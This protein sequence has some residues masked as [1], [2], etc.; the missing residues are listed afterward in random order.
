MLAAELALD[1]PPD[2]AEVLLQELQDCSKAQHIHETLVRPGR[3]WFLD[4]LKDFALPGHLM[5]R[6]I[7]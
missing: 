3:E 7:E 2:E 5:L 6:I 1:V 4:F